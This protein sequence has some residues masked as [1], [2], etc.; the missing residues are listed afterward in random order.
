[1][2]SSTENKPSSTELSRAQKAL[3]ESIQKQK[4]QEKIIRQLQTQKN[5]IES[6]QV[7]IMRAAEGLQLVQ[8]RNEVSFFFF[9]FFTIMSF[10]SNICDRLDFACLAKCVPFF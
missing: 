10:F 4:A 9:L 5:H 3:E 1:M 2:S 8:R 7:E 6:R